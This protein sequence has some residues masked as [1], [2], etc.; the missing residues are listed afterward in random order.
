[1]KLT[2]LSII[3]VIILLP[4]I[5]I[6]YVN[7]S[8]VIKAEKEE[9]YYKKVIDSA[10]RDATDQMKQIENSD[11]TID[12]GYSGIVDNKVSINAK[13]A[14]NTFYNSLFNTFNIQASEGARESF[15]KYIP[16][17]AVF[18]YDGVYINSAEE[19]ANGEIQYILKPKQYYT[20]TYAIKDN[21]ILQ[22]PRY[23]I[24]DGEELNTAMADSN[25]VQ[26]TFTMDDYIYVDIYSNTGWV[27][28]GSNDT[29]GKKYSTA[30]YLSDASLNGILVSGEVVTGITSD[31]R[32]ELLE[33][34]IELLEEKRKQTIIDVT[35]ASI[36]EAVNRHNSLAEM[37]GMKYNFTFTI[38][39]ESDWYENIEGIGM[40][41]VVQGISL[42]NRYLNY[43][44]YSM[45]SLILSKKYYISKEIINHPIVDVEYLN[46]DMYHVSEKCPIYKEYVFR[47]MNEYTELSPKFYYNKAEAGANGYEPCPVCK[48]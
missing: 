46:T 34:L 27:W 13:V 25:I 11:I 9:M 28:N 23:S 35:S 18:D 42:G 33:T 30:F 24:V 36:T 2:D 48:P 19:L 37:L 7:T 5:M 21:G 32:S 47:N 41:A 39:E 26:I 12:Y 1:M 38:G 14:V 43:N 22:N 44:G 17:I 4:F 31:E 20:Y 16:V 40:L 10:L 15:K 8:F 29:L 3:F 45:S 6:V